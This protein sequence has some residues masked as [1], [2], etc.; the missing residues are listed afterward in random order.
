MAKGQMDPGVV[1]IVST[2]ITVLFGGGLA[3]W[4]THARRMDARRQRDETKQ[5]EENR[6]V[7][8]EREETL[9]AERRQITGEYRSEVAALRL[10]MA[11]AKQSSIAES[12]SLRRRI[13]ELETEVATLQ[14]T[15]AMNASAL[16]ASEARERVKQASLDQEV[17][18][19]ALLSARNHELELRSTAL[20]GELMDL[21]RRL[22][23]LE[24]RPVVEVVLPDAV[25][26]GSIRVG[27]DGSVIEADSGSE[28]IY[29]AKLEGR[30]ILDMI[31]QR[32]RAAHLDGFARAARG[33]LLDVIAHEH[34]LVM[35]RADES[36]IEVLATI[37]QEVSTG[38]PTC[39]V[40]EF[41]V[42]QA[43]E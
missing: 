40:M 15:S 39:F 27:M 25:G 3:G 23:K 17:Q 16:A 21:Q 5:Q 43:E 2:A 12:E 13:V 28:A 30:S 11:T 6:R 4:F 32:F 18:K 36:E 42:S 10:E 1:N 38:N 24:R 41:E 34:R 9:L 7:D 22:A 29:G 37:R 35:L 31:P 20:K 19:N 8:H 14:K 33:E 26:F